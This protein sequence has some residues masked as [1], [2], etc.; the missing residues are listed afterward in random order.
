VQRNSPA[1]LK[2]KLMA[3][4]DTDIRLIVEVIRISHLGD[5]VLPRFLLVYIQDSYTTLSN[6]Q[7]MV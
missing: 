4:L 2:A 6:T 1:V 5:S 3:Q 7:D